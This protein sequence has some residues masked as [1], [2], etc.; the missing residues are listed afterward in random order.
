MRRSAKWQSAPD[1]RILEI[2]A[3]D[4]DGIVKVGNLAKH[5]YIHVS[6]S[7]VSRRCK[8]LA[9]NHLLRKIGDGVYVITDEGRGY[10]AGEYDVESETFVETSSQKSAS[11]ESEKGA[12]GV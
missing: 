10:L 9:D 6:Q 11:A 3:E 8:K 12:N 5:D 7:Q 2:A 4:E 1:D